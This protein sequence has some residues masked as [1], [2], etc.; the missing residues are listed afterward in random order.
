MTAWGFP[1]GPLLLGDEV[2]LDVGA[3]IAVILADAFGDR[4][5]GPSM[6][7]GMSADDRKGRKNGRGFY[8]YEDGQRKG[9][10]ET[11]YDALGLGQR[12]SISREEIQNRLSLAFINEAALCLQEGILRSARDGD[13]GA[14]FGLGYPPFKGGPFWTVDQM[15]ADVV[16]QK[17][18]ALAEIHGDRFNPAQILKDHAES[19]ETFR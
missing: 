5:T 7:D 9:V 18:E 6:M 10:D 4:M 2:G 15:G 3:H 17:L 11:V 13:I 14:V 19:G 12:K 8:L 16:V 1:L